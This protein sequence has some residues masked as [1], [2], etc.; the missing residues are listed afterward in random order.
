MDKYIDDFCEEYF[1]EFEQPGIKCC[2]DALFD[3]QRMRPFLFAR[4]LVIVAIAIIGASFIIPF[5]VS[6]K[7][8]ILKDLGVGILSSALVSIYFILREK[9]IQY[10][11]TIIAIIKRRIR[12]GEDA[13]HNANRHIMNVSN[14]EGL[15]LLQSTAQNLFGVVCYFQGKLPNMFPADLSKDIIIKLV[16]EGELSEKEILQHIQNARRTINEL[17]RRLDE[18][19]WNVKKCM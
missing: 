17:L 1:S 10:Y 13:L 19:K 3:N 15:R 16:I 14:F 8:N 12:S 9:S 11:K 18:M 4:I 7:S 5:E 6:C 2:T